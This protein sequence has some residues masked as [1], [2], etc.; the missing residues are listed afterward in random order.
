MILPI[1]AGAFGLWG[2]TETYGYSYNN[3]FFWNSADTDAGVFGML[4]SNLISENDI[5]R[6]NTAFLK[7]S[8]F[9]VSAAK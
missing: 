1:L 4:S 6:E 8:L 2:S 9:S 3:T 5:F 7:G